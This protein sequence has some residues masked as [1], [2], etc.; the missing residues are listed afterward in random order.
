[1]ITVYQADVAVKKIAALEIE[2]K[3]LFGKPVKVMFQFMGA[4]DLNVARVLNAVETVTGVSTETMISSVR[5]REASEARQHCFQ[6][7]R[8]H[9]QMTFVGIAKVFDRDHSTVIYGLETFDALYKTDKRYREVHDQIAKLLFEGHE[10]G[11]EA[12]A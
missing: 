2:L 8:R 7:M 10:G 11:A 4:E 3:R 5:T 6:L 12:D 1:M 9:L